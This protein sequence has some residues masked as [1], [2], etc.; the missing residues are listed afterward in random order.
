MST[1]TNKQHNNTMSYPQSF[2]ADVLGRSTTQAEKIE[3]LFAQQCKHMHGTGAW[4]SFHRAVQNI[5][6]GNA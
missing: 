5:K 3:S 6:Q 1:T 4:W 2:I